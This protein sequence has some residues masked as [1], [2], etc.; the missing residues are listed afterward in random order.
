MTTHLWGT[1]LRV[2]VRPASFAVSCYSQH[3]KGLLL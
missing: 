3:M 1:A 2:P